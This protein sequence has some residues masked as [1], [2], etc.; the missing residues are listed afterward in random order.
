MLC[1]AGSYSERQLE[2]AENS[3]KWKQVMED[4]Q[5]I[6]DAIDSLGG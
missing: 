4:C 2:A 3:P 1:K 6:D 5:A